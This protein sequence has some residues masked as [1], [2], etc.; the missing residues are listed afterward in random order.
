M[1]ANVTPTQ[2]YGRL[3]GDPP[4]RAS[5]RRAAAS[6]TAAP[7][8]RS[9]SRSPSRRAGTA[10]SGS[11][12]RRS[13][14]SRP[15]ST[16]SRAPSTRPSAACCRPRRRS[17]C[18]QPLTIDPSRA[19]EGKGLLWIQLQELPW[20]V[21]GDAAGELDTGDGTWTEELRERYADRIQA[22]LARHI[23]NLESSILR[24]DA[25]SP[26]DL[27]GGEPEPPP[28]RPVRAARSR[29]TR[30]S[31]GGRSRAARA[32]DA[33]RAALAHRR[34]HLARPGSRRRLGHDRRAGAARAAAR[35]ARARRA[36]RARCGVALEREDAAPAELDGEDR[37]RELEVVVQRR[38]RLSGSCATHALEQRRRRAPRGGPAVARLREQRR[39]VALAAVPCR[40]DQ[41]QQPAGP[42]RLVEREVKGGCA[43]T[44]RA[45]VAV[46]PRRVGRRRAAP[47]AA[48]RPSASKSSAARRTA[49][50]SSAS[51]PRTARAAPR[52][53]APITFAPW[54]GTCSAS[55]SASSWRTASRIGEMLIAERAR[56]ILEPQRRARREL[57]EDDRLS[58][59][60]QRGL[61]HRAM[62]RLDAGFLGAVRA[63]DGASRA[64]LSTLLIRCQTTD[65]IAPSTVR[66]RV[67]RRR[68]E[69][70]HLLGD[71]E[72]AWQVAGDD[73]RRGA[74]AD[75]ERGPA[76]LR[77]LRDHRAL[78]LPEVLDLGEPDR[79][80]S[81]PPRSARSEINFRTL[82]HVLPFHNP[83]VLA[84]QIA[85][86]RHPPRGPLRVRRRARP[87]LDAD[88]GRDPARPRL[89]RA[90]RGGASSCSS[91]R[92]TRTRSRSTASTSRSTDT[93]I[94]PRPRPE[95]PRLPR[96]HLRSHVRRSRPS[97][98]GRSSCRR[99]C[100]TRRSRTSSTST[101]TRC[102]E[103]GTT[104]DIVWIHA[105]Y[106]DE[107]RDTARREAEQW[108]KGFLAGTRRR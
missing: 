52:R 25:L 4:D 49:S 5:P 55:P 43:R 83:I 85:V 33:G 16:A 106:I 18:G 20:H 36:P 69:V 39:P 75:R 87:R 71:P 22:R 6:A 102:A 41:A 65:R 62:A 12:R 76:R 57:A 53:R 78:L 28:R 40:A 107:D 95:V 23:P 29:S 73:V 90:L 31:S 15:A 14:T 38:A 48:P 99:S 103:H 66:H 7:R 88:Q 2:L 35:A 91:P 26:A 80:S 27:A 108:M 59:L 45:H 86:D 44:R 82:L 9:T 32:T 72:L 51:R 100:P 24:A 60:G 54:C 101:A 21:K 19:P 47:R 96:R 34:E 3:L 74:R 56:E 30:T 37:R 8:C 17:S 92:S 70:Q 105:C 46:V 89:A 104:P 64:Q 84:H 1:I 98:A 81:R 10:T 77:R 61:G 50:V 11:A 97:A 58:Q 93:G 63:H 67:D 94:V 42:R 79:R 13:S 68:F